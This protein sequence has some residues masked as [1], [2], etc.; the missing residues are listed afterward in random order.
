MPAQDSSSSLYQGS[1][2]RGISQKAV[3]ILNHDQETRT[4]SE[5]AYTSN[6]HTNRR[7]YSLHKF[8]VH[9]SNLYEGSSE[10]PGLELMTRLY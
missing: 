4:M 8:N 3:V 1:K 6:Y 2:Y 5:L 10:A 7:T 9:R